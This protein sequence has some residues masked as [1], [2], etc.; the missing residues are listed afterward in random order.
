MNRAFTY[1]AIRDCGYGKVWSR[2]ADDK[3]DALAEARHWMR[4]GRKDGGMNGGDYFIQP[5]N[6]AANR[7]A[8]AA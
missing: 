4:E 2:L 8:V 1:E 3:E 5:I 7:E 6:D